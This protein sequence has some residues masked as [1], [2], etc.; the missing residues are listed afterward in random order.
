MVVFL[1]GYLGAGR[2]PFRKWKQT[3]AARAVRV[4]SLLKAM[5]WVLGRLT[6]EENFGQANISALR[7]RVDF[8]GNYAELDKLAK[9]TGGAILDPS[10]GD[11]FTF[12]ALRRGPDERVLS[13]LVRAAY[14][15]VRNVYRVE[16]EWHDSPQQPKSLWFEIRD[17]RGRKVRDD[18]LHYPS[19]FVPEGQH[20]QAGF[21]R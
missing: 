2:K 13:R 10:G 3:L 11:I 14:W 6:V 8:A 12:A 18:A 16:F 20:R 5:P 9:E 17:S 19:H 1:D 4:F 21:R 15:L 7:R